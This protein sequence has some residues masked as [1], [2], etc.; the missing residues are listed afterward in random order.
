M[1]GEP[2]FSQLGHYLLGG[3]VAWDL[4]ADECTQIQYTVISTRILA[5]ISSRVTGL[6]LIGE[7][8]PKPL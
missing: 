6:G 7:A 2:S 3:H 4:G 1:L 5:F 8:F